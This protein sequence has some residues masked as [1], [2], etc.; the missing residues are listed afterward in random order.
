MAVKSVV[1]EPSHDPRD[2][3]VLD[4]PAC[5]GPDEIDAAVAQ[6]LEAAPWSPRPAQLSGATGSEHSQMHW[7][8]ARMSW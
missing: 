6:A 4:G 2:G 3:T 5:T 7:R 1:T 8:R